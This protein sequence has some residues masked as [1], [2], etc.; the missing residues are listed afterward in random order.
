MVCRTCCPR[1]PVH[2][3]FHPWIIWICPSEAK[4]DLKLI[5]PNRF[6]QNTLEKIDFKTFEPLPDSVPPTVI[7]NATY[8]AGV[9]RKYNAYY[10]QN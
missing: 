4:R 9:Y 7:T 3:I 10:R 1:P 5:T 8:F 2:R 6:W